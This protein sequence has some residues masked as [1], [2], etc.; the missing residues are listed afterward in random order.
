MKIIKNKKKIDEM[1]SKASNIFI[2][3][4]KYLDL[5]AIG[6]YIWIC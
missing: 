1:I 5:D 6:R 2:V 4:H 3:G